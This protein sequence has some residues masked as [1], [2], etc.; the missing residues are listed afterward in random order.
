MTRGPAVRG[1]ALLGFPLLLF[2]LVRAWLTW[3]SSLRHGCRN[4]AFGRTCHRRKDPGDI[5]NYVTRQ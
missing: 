1:L 4:R 5:K 2:L 3:D